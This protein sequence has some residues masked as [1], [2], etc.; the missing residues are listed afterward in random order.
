MICFETNQTVT[1]RWKKDKKLTSLFFSSPKLCGLILVVSGREWERMKDGE[2]QAKISFLTWRNEIVSPVLMR[3]RTKGFKRTESSWDK[4]RL[5]LPRSIHS[6]G[7][8]R[9]SQEWQRTCDR[10]RERGR[11]DETWFILFRAWN[12]EWKEK[13]LNLEPSHHLSTVFPDFT[14][15]DSYFTLST[16]LCHHHDSYL[17]LLLSLSL[18]LSRRHIIE[19]TGFL[20]RCSRQD[21]EVRASYLTV[22]NT[23]EKRV[24]IER[25]RR[26]GDGERER[27]RN[28]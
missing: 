28:K 7:F 15:C 17:L 10:E 9:R 16:T 5:I 26:G 2:K 11:R 14:F 22:T 23:K 4:L 25:K 18:S 1:F 8:V 24:E 27:V 19:Y 13:K 6:V 12:Q 3:G 20:V 21:E